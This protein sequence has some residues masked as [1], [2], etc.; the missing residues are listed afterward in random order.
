M[1]RII[2]RAFEAK[3]G[4][5]RWWHN[6]SKSIIGKTKAGG[7]KS[8]EESE[9]AVNMGPADAAAQIAA[10]LSS[11]KSVLKVFQ[12]VSFLITGHD[13][14]ELEEAFFKHTAAPTCAR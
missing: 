6:K 13:P 3:V 8:R 2:R 11:G 10:E 7:L 5:S 4:A 14:A 12:K 9:A 1:R